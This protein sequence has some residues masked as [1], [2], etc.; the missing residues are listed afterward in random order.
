[1]DLNYFGALGRRHWLKVE[2]VLSSEFPYKR[3]T[4]P[5]KLL[6]GRDKLCFFYCSLEYNDYNYDKLELDSIYYI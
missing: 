2:Y 5:N 6:R 3:P 4:V 1:L